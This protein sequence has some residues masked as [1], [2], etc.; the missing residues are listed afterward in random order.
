MI[1]EETYGSGQ[2]RPFPTLH[3]LRLLNAEEVM[4]VPTQ[5]VRLV[6][7]MEVQMKLAIKDGFRITLYL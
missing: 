1:W 3:F 4:G 5:I 7:V 2:Q 6:I